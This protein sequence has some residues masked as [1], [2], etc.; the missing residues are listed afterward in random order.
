[1]SAIFHADDGRD[2]FDLPNVFSPRYHDLRD[3]KVVFA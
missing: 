1:M 2:G 3:P